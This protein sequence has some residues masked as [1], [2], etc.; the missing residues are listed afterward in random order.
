MQVMTP[1]TAAQRV[2]DALAATDTPEP[3]ADLFAEGAVTWHSFDEVEE[4]TQV[5]TIATLRAIRA[6]IPDFTMSDGPACWI[7]L[8]A[9][10]I[11]LV[12][13]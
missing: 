2:L 1:S 9:R 4:P 11:A 8:L 6:V 13:P 3:P 7:H 5:H 10:T 12:K